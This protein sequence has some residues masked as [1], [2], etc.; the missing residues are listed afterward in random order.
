[1]VGPFLGRRLLARQ[2]RLVDLETRVTAAIHQRHRRPA[3]VER[4]AS[5]SS[6][7][8]RNGLI[9]QIYKIYIGD[10]H[11]KSLTMISL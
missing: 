11:Y 6:P 10:P 3:S 2:T 8:L 9:G 5:M 1:M 4:F 7:S